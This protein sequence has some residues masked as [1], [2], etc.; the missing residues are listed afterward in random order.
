VANPN[1]RKGTEH[2]VKT[3]DFLKA[4]GQPYC[5]RMASSGSKDRG[6]LTGV[7]GFVIGCKDWGKIDLAK[8]M[9][10]IRKQKHN[11]GDVP[12]GV[13]IIK[14]RNHPIGRA[15]AVMELADLAALIADGHPSLDQQYREL[16][17]LL[18]ND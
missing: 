15:Y 10:E 1:K 14:R 12:F 16:S 9:D 6:D 18:G 8:F 7:P 4:H 3:R 17:A 11:A 13:E 2:E 5:E